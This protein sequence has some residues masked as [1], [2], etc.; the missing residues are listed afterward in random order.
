MPRPYLLEFRARAVALV[1]ALKQAKQTAV[2]LGINPVTLSTWT[3]QGDIDDGRR[4]VS[5][6]PSRQSCALRDAAFESVRRNC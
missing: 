4:P 6:P 5:P 3:R 1:R 2:E